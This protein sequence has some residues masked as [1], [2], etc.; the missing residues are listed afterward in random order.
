MSSIYLAIKIGST[1]TTIY[2]QGDGL[3]LKE[4]SL[5][6]ISGS[7]VKSREIRAI[8]YEARNLQGRHSYGIS[9]VSPIVD[10]LV[11]NS[12]L[13]TLMLRGFI[14]KV[15]PDR[16]FRPN[17][18]A[19][20]CVPLGIT[21]EDKKTFQKV[22]Y[23][24]GIT[25]VTILPA[26]I[27]NAIGLDTNIENKFGKL[28]VNIGGGC[29][30]IAVLAQNSIVQGVSLNIG[31]KKINTAIEQYVLDKYN[32]SISQ[33]TSEKIKQD[34]ASLI[35]TYSSTVDIEGVD[36]SSKEAKLITLTSSEL[37]PIMDFYFGKIC[38]AIETVISSCPP[39]IVNDVYKEGGY[40]GGSQVVFPGLEKY[41][42]NRLGM[43]IHVSEIARTDI[44]GAGK[45][46]D[47]P[48]LLKKIVLAN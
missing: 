9:V 8:G 19:L 29:T 24:A 25:D 3:V 44:W 12:E 30:N 10:G 36:N 45:L 31:G 17:I 23:S 42:R 33:Q 22:C 47:D 28:F 39:D 32:L 27:C 1:T 11:N 5:I 18:R 38:D 16:L 6:A 34:I 40:F 14:R 21:A 26:I 7:A 41:L 4:P 2:R 13:A 43:Q 46:I 37:Y 20:L 48:L 35:P 15:C